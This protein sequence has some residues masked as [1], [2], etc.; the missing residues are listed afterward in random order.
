MSNSNDFRAAAKQLLAAALQ[1]EVAEVEDD[2]AIGVT[3]RWDSLAHMRLIMGIEEHMGKPVDTD[4]MVAIENLDSV[5][6]ILAA[7]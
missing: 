3:D 4:A 5:E 2:A 1:L 7:G 6:A